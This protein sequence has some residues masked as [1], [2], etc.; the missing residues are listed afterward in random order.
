MK[1]TQP[2]GRYIRHVRRSSSETTRAHIG[3]PV[4]SGALPRGLGMSAW[5]DVSTWSC[6]MLL[7]GVRRQGGV[8][9][10]TYRGLIEASE[11]AR[12]VQRYHV[13]RPR[14]PAHRSGVRLRGLGA[15]A[16]GRVSLVCGIKLVVGVLVPCFLWTLVGSHLALDV[17]YKAHGRAAVGLA[18]WF[19]VS[20]GLLSAL[21]SLWTYSICSGGDG[22]RTRRTRLLFWDGV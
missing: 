5:P 6:M 2:P 11:S 10:C 9:C 21:T 12:E 17:W 3:G 22:V 15:S 7:K 18:C 20:C 14:P 19:F 13:R 16:C 8:G 4:W 1:Q